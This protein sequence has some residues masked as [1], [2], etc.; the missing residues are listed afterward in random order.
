MSF[1]NFL[2]TNRNPNIVCILF[3]MII[4]PKLCGTPSTPYVNAKKEEI[5]FSTHTIFCIEY[6]KPIAYG[7]LILPS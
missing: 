3:V 2:S 6:I 4:D 1:N 7:K 5:I